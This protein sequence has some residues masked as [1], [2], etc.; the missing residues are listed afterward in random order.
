MVVTIME[1]PPSV[2]EPGLEQLEDEEATEDDQDLEKH[3]DLRKK[4]DF[5]RVS[6]GIRSMLRTGIFGPLYSRQ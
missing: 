3:L 1:G 5:V 2:S 4:M 6:Q